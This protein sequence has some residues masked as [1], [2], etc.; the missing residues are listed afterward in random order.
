MAMDWVEGRQ[1]GPFVG[2]M[3]VAEVVVAAAVDAVLR[4]NSNPEATE[5]SRTK[6]GSH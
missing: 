1:D 3:T 6:E 5:K 4:W 2:A